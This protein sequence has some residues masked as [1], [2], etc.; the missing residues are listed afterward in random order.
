MKDKGDLELE[1]IVLNEYVFVL[2]EELRKGL[3]GQVE[4]AWY[5]EVSKLM[6]LLCSLWGGVVS[7]ARC[8]QPCA[9]LWL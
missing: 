1:I 8:E 9:R 3:E 5:P 4:G 2:R 6:M 7:C